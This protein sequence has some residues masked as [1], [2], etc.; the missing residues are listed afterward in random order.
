M[1]FGR[2]NIPD[3]FVS[4]RNTIQ[5]ILFTALFALIF[6]NVY[7]PFGAD[8]WYDVSWWMFL[9]ASGL[10]VLAGMLVVIISRLLMFW[11]KSHNRITILG[12]VVM[13]LAEILLMGGLYALLERITLGG[14]R[15]FTLLY[16]VSVQNASLILL[17][18]YSV[19]L[20]YFSW[21]EKK[22]SLDAL[23]KQ[24]R[25]KPQFIAFKD[26]NNV[27]RFTIK[28][29]DL[30]Y[31]SA[32]DNYVEIHYK[33]GSKLKKYLLRNTLKRMEDQFHELPLLRCHRS[34]MVNLDQV[35]MFKREK[36]QISLWMDDEGEIAIPVSR[37]YGKSVTDIFGKV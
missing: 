34:Y 12:Y 33:S 2:K 37:S 3:F 18:P 32:S 17:I 36:G 28:A 6:I 10:L 20:L 7:R 29:G 25:S 14:V 13:V 35:K 9:F 30:I 31:L 5:Q 8:Q 19:S 21:R 4:K 11:I 1:R 27:L 26:E 24:L 23:L 22:M 16:F 15:P